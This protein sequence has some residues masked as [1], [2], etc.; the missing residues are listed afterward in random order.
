MARNLHPLRVARTCLMASLLQ[1]LDQH[2]LHSPSRIRRPRS[3]L[4]SSRSYSPPTSVLHGP[5]R[6]GMY[7]PRWSIV[8]GI[9]RRSVLDTRRR[10]R[11]LTRSSSRRSTMSSRISSGRLVS[12]QWR[13]LYRDAATDSSINSLSL[14]SVRSRRCAITSTLAD[15][16]HVRCSSAY[17]GSVCIFDSIRQGSESF[18]MSAWLGSGCLSMSTRQGCDRFSVAGSVP[19]DLRLLRTI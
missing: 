2:V 7:H 4:H 14:C 6:D 9:N 13:L 18:S 11:R 16:A 1:Y 17:N 8:M 15:A 10:H 12:R 3:A 19:L 5:M